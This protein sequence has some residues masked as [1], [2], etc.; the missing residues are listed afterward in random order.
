MAA[1][2]R[3]GKSSRCSQCHRITRAVRAT[4]SF[5]Y[6]YSGWRTVKRFCRECVVI[7][8][9]LIAV[10]QAY[11]ITLPPDPMMERTRADAAGVKGR[12]PLRGA[13]SAPLT[14]AVGA[15]R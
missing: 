2:T 1:G 9:D 4:I 8:A 7:I 14:P 6:P 11:E 13:R 3:L 10:L 5:R 12:R 15:A